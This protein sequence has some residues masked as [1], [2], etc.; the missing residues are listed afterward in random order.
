MVE[1]QVMTEPFEV[2]MAFDLVG[3]LPTAKGGFVSF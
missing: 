3:P 1:R 2:V